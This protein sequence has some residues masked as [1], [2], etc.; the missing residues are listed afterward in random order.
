MQKII[1][2]TA[3]SIDGYIA[4]PDG[5]LDWLTNFPNPDNL[6]HGYNDLLANTSC[7]IMGRKT[8]EE[9]VGFG[10]EWPYKGIPTYILT[11]NSEFNCK[12]PDTLILSGN[13]VE[14]VHRIR[15]EQEKNIW[16]AGGGQVVKY[17]L[18]NGLID[19]MIISVIPI[20]LGEG[21]PLFPGKSK[22]TKFKLIENQLFSTGIINLTFD[23]VDH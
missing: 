10:I 1:L 11:A 12:T 17:F 8:Y 2:F 4:R 23:I 18:Q 6:D 14:K 15:S 7:I 3:C 9:I 13:L 16:L 20:I 5:N 19:R 21:I 22:E